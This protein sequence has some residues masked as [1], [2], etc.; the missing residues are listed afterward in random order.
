MVRNRVSD[1]IDHVPIDPKPSKPSRKPPPEP[2][3]LPDYQPIVISNPLTYGQ[4]NLPDHVDSGSPYAIFSL[5]FTEYHLGIFADNTNQYAESERAQEEEDFK[6]AR[7]WYLT[8]VPELRAYIATYIWMGLHPESAVEDFWNTNELH[9]PIYTAVTRSLSLKGWQ[10]ID[11][12]FHISK[13]PEPGHIAQTPFD[14]MEPLSEYLRHT[15]KYYWKTAS[16][17][18]VDETIP[19]FMGRSKETVNI[20]SKSVPEGFKIWVLANA[21]YVLDWLYHAKGDDAGPVD[22]DDYWTNDRGFSKTQA[23]VLDLLKQK[24]ISEHQ[25]HVVWLDNLFTSARLLSV[26]KEEV[27][28]AAGTVPTTKTRQEIIEE[29][30]GTT[31]EK[32]N[33]KE[34]NRGLDPALSALKMEHNMQLEWGKLYACLSADGSVLQFAW[35]DQN[36]VLFMSTVSN[37]KREIL[38]AR[39]R[40][41]RTATS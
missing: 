26:L 9:G 24:G 39:R 4:G 13:L 37:G 38:R 6:H 41:A 29:T 11:K 18:A 34:V 14:K 27:F 7:P 30:S 8:T 10:Q 22:L 15:F 20:P 33:I 5:F 12:F 21:G 40:P 19:R 2:W 1:D 36:V 25:Q 17:V 3:P 23:V 31:A 28:G 35:K 32:N 16:H